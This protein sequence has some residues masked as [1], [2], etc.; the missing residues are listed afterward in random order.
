MA[1]E[2]NPM[3]FLDCAKQYS[4]TKSPKCGIKAF[5]QNFLKL[6]SIFMLI[7]IS[8]YSAAV[9]FVADVYRL[10]GVGLGS[11]LTGK[12]GCAWVG[13][14]VVLKELNY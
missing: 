13:A 8:N 5:E 1:V 12:P 11:G 9:S 7:F 3:A 6:A 14:W 2:H 10:G 4:E